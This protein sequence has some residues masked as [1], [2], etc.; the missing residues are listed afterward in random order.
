MKSKYIALLLVLFVSTSFYA[1]NLNGYK[2][3]IIPK[4]Y[5]F[6]KYDDQYQLNS[7]TKFLFE[8]EGFKAIYSNE[9]LPDD[10]FDNPCLGINVKV[11]EKSNLFAT[12]LAI[13]LYNCQNQKVLESGLGFS[14]IKDFKRGHHDAL[15]QAFESVK[16]Q[17]YAFDAS[18]VQKSKVKKEEVEVTALPENEEVVVSETVTPVSEKVSEEKEE[19]QEEVTTLPISNDEKLEVRNSSGEE[20]SFSSTENK[21]L[22]AQEISNGFQLVDS[23]PKIVFKALKS[24][25]KDIYYLQNQAGVLYKENGKWYAEYYKNEMLV[26]E[27]L[28]IKF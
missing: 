16:A 3:A 11:N 27:E 13:E 19:V 7:L 23:T 20:V 18:K 26:K 14:K 8:K 9:R 28:S 2:Y 10:L 12:K 24:N 15:R 6:L 1:Q 25:T 17:N 22:Y 5:D 4:K 21:V